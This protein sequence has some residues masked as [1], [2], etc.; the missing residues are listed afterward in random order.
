M[1]YLSPLRLCS[2]GTRPSP[3]NPQLNRNLRATIVRQFFSLKDLK[4]N[5]QYS[6]TSSLRDWW[7][8]DAKYRALC[9]LVMQQRNV[10]FDSGV[11]LIDDWHLNQFRD[12]AIRD[13]TRSEPLKT[14]AYK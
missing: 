1:H 8:L 11:Q 6:A 3:A 12:G 9:S 13:R 7:V 14:L 5:R 10:T 4:N 2:A